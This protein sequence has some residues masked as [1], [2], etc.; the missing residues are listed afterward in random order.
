[1]SLKSKPHVSS[2]A[3]LPDDAGTT[4]RIGIQAPGWQLSKAPVS[5]TPA[6]DLENFR[7]N[8][9]FAFAFLIIIYTGRQK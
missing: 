7:K 8:Y 1:M 4:S 6:F 9:F 3:G 5:G 2:P